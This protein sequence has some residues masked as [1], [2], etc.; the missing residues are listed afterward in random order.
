MSIRAELEAVMDRWAEAIEADDAAA[1]AALCTADA[2]FLSSDAPTARGRDE[3]ESLVRMWIDAG[4]RNDRR[5]TLAS[6]HSDDLGWLA[7]A[8]VVDFDADDGEGVVTESGRYVVVFRRE[9]DREWRIEA[10][11]IFA[12][13]LP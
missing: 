1:C 7:C 11:S 9:A 4:E 13:D 12:S 8:Y 6:G 2:V 10:L 5:A 3:I